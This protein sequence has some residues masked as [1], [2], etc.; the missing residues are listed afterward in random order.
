MTVPKKMKAIVCH[1]PEDYRLEEVDVPQPETG[2]VLVRVEGVGI[3]AS[4]FKCYS[5]APLFWGDDHRSGYCQ[6]PIIPG[7]EFVGKVVA[8]G[9]GAAEKHGFK[10]GDRVISEQIVPCG[11]CRYC[12]QGYYWMCERNTVY[13]FR[14]LAPGAMAEYMIFPAESRNHMV[15]VSLTLEE[16]VYI[17]P[18]ACVLNCTLPH[19][20]TYLLCQIISPYFTWSNYI[21]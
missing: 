11:E 21:I 12:K 9:E 10:I 4:D 20:K 14:Q 6:P 1:G 7:H 2:E 13:G 15:S 3:C 8:L 18:L 19:F 5:G 16:T 17:E